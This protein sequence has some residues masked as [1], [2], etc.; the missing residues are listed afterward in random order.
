MRAVF[1]SLAAISGVAAI[2][3]LAWLCWRNSE[4]NFLPP[5]KRAEWI[6]F[7]AAVDA[8]SRN[9]VDMD[10]VFRREFTLGS[11]TAGAL[12]QVRAAKRLEL[13]VNDQKVDLISSRTWK[14]IASADI[15]KLLRQGANRI[16]ARVFNNNGPPALW[17]SLTG[18]EVSVRSD[19]NWT[20]SCAGSAWRPTTL[21][22]SPRF[23]GRG[24]SIA[25]SESTTTS[26]IKVW[27]LWLVFGVVA[28]VLCVGGNWLFR[29]SS[30]NADWM[31][32]GIVFSFAGLWLI[33]FWHNAKLLPPAIGFDAQ[34]HLNYI[35]YLQD[36]H[37]LPLPAEGNEMFQP[38][39]YYLISAAL[40]S[41]FH[42]SATAPSAILVLRAFTMLCG[43]V[44]VVLVFASLRLIFPGRQNL[45]LIGAGLAAFLPMNLYMSHYPTNETLAG[46]LASASV[47]LALRILISRSSSWQSYAFLGLLLGAALLTKATAVLTVPFIILALFRQL[48]AQRASV[49][50][51]ATTLG[52]MVLIAMLLSSWHYLRVSSHGS[53]IVGSWD[54][55]AGSFW[56]QDDGY[57][58]I[59]YFCRF[60]ASLVRPLFSATA[61]FMDGIYST[62]WGDGLCGGVSGL[63]AR[64]PWNYGVMCAG[65]LLSL[66]PTSILFIGAVTVAAQLFRE[67]RSDLFVLVGLCAALAMALVYYSLKVPCYGSVKA[68][69]G[70]SALIPLGL[71][72]ATGWN[73]LTRRSR[74]LR[75]SVGALLLVWAVNSFASFWINDPVAQHRNVAV[76]LLAD[77]KGDAALTEAR[78]A[79]DANASNAGARIVLAT[80]LAE[81]GQPSE[82]LE[83][84]ERATELAPLDGATHFEL[85]LLLGRQNKLERAVEEARLAVTAAPENTRAHSLLLASLLNTNEDAVDA[86]R[87]ALAVSPF[88][89]EIHRLLGAALMRNYDLV[90]AFHQLS[91]SV[92]LKPNLKEAHSDLH[93][94]LLSLVNSPDAPELLHQ[95]ASSIPASIAALGDLAWILCDSPS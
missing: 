14:D 10:T 62:V 86:G 51:W 20:A 25:A 35:Q 53:P 1:I 80:T 48:L 30:V 78:K 81:A 32:I 50:K 82:A 61:S 44:Q 73:I 41:L 22:T 85:G 79:V 64:P 46:V 68:F 9:V 49:S 40:L 23:P 45:Q 3:S 60:G 63:V 37:R 52:S 83:E 43:I 34:E 59:S 39:L 38:P 92:L 89:A 42:L 69:Y 74:L 24:Y 77:K 13:T 2:A 21:A 57:Q 6:L 18:D 56:W 75:L 87:E 91:Y 67:L 76:H 71:F 31:T 11:S 16:E 65:Y 94:A 4:I 5:D 90:A 8:G 72:A 12:L 66:L 58:T 55:T 54:P 88:D 7:P 27:R 15:S 84:A 28:L 19:Q 17:L 47:Y 33:L 36:R 29:R 93:R 70:L 26:L 95:A